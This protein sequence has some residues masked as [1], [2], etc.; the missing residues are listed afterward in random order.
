M[1]LI[2]SWDKIIYLKI[3][4]TGRFSI[5]LFIRM[6]KWSLPDIGLVRR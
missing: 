5:K 6:A 1:D 2:G 4:E 3:L